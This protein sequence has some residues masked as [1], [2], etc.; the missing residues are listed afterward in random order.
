MAAK[1]LE[2]ESAREHIALQMIDAFIE[3]VAEEMNVD[4]DGLRQALK[5]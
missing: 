5:S 2:R 4:E 1:N 3:S